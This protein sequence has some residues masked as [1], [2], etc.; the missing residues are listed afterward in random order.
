MQKRVAGLFTQ[1]ALDAGEG[2]VHTKLDRQPIPGKKP[3][4]WREF[5]A[6]LPGAMSAEE[7]EAFRRGDLVAA[8][9]PEFAR[10]RLKRPAPLPG[11]MLRLVDRVPELDAA[12]G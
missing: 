5:V 4:D 2:I 12:G 10:A 8:F 1:A 7:V 3:A 6:V 11:G 9:G